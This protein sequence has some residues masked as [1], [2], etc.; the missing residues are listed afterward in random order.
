MHAWE[1]RPCRLSIPL[2]CSGRT[3]QRGRRRWLHGSHRG[4]SVVS[5]MHR[6]CLFRHRSWH[7][8]VC[9][10]EDETYRFRTKLMVLMPRET[11]I[12][13]TAWPAWGRDFKEV[14]LIWRRG[15][16][17]LFAPFCKTQSPSLRS[18]NSD[19]IPWAVAGLTYRPL[20]INI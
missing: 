19:S 15:L 20:N 18:T 3:F 13:M 8:W 12:C 1:T 2:P 17:A 11:A 6:Y 14:D 16:T 7:I 10:G 9:F 5:S 4:I